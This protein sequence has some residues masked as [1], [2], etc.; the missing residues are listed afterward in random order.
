MQQSQPLRV[1]DV[2]QIAPDASDWAGGCFAIVTEVKSWGMQG[3]VQ[4]PC[5]SRGD[6]ESGG[7]AFIRLKSEQF[8]RIGR[9]EWSD[10]EDPEQ[11]IA[12]SEKL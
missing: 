7:R 8:V 11:E 10:R 4:M 3:F 1:N 6:P 5:T 12:V 2:V 9:A